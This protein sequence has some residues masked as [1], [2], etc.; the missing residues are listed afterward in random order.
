MNLDAQIVDLFDTLLLPSLHEAALELLSES[1]CSLNRFLG[2]Q[3]AQN[4]IS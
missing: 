3:V 2:L 1:N 4:L